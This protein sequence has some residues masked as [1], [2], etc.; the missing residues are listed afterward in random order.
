MRS[1]KFHIS[2][3]CLFLLGCNLFSQ[4][5]QISGL[6]LDGKTNSPIEGASIYFDNTTIG[7]T[8]NEKGEFLLDYNKN[9]KTTLIISYLGYVSERFNEIESNDS[10]K[11]Y[12]FESEEELGE[13][14]LTYDDGWTRELK[15][16]E[17]R[18]HYLGESSNGESCKILNEDD[19]TLIYD[20]K[21][22]QLIAKCLNPIII[23]N[24]SLKFI[25]SVE[26]AHF[27]INYSFVSNNKRRLNLNYVYYSGTNFFQSTQKHPT[28]KTLEKRM[29]AYNGSVLHFMRALAQDEL[30]KNGYRVY[31][32]NNP[33]KTNRYITISPIEESNDV[34]VR[35]KGQLNILYKMKQ[36]SSI[37]SLVDEFHINH[38]GNHSP[39]EKIRFGGHLGG[40]R[41]GDALPLDFLLVKHSSKK[42]FKKL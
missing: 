29:L 25:I 20:A 37:Q 31:L 40:Q 22:K 33:V 27:E 18:K 1:T 16:K 15:L 30:R 34:L 42:E 7:T 10:M 41:M 24:K 9:I 35:L 23:E 8:T 3:I 11:I 17:F 12:L 26:L 14:L 2:F 28:K 32:G 39:A 21:R 5:K 38:F 36:Q 4:Q 19:I 13:V 6:V